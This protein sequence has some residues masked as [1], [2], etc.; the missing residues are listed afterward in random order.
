MIKAPGT[1]A[2]YSRFLFALFSA[3][4]ILAV[5]L[6]S[7]CGSNSDAVIVV[8]SEPIMYLYAEQ[9]NSQHQGANIEVHYNS[10]P[11]D[12]RNKRQVMPD[13]LIQPNPAGTYQMQWFQPLSV[14]LPQETYPQL[15][16]QYSEVSEKR[17]L[18][19]AF[20]LP[21]MVWHGDQPGAELP[22]TL[23]INQLA[24]MN[25]RKPGEGDLEYVQFLP[26][27]NPAFLHWHLRSRGIHLNFQEEGVPS[28]NKDELMRE[29]SMLQDW[30][31][32]QAGTAAQIERFQE[33]YLYAPYYALLR[34]ERVG[35]YAADLQEYASLPA[36][37]KE[38]LD[39]AWFGSEG[40]IPVLSVLYAAIPV[41]SRHK[42]EAQQFLQWLISP[43]TQKE[44][45]EYTLEQELPDFGFFG[46]L[47]A[48][49]TVNEE[50]I[51]R[52]FPQLQG[53]SPVSSR[54][55]FPPPMPYYWQELERDVIA[56]FLLD[57]ILED[58]PPQH[59]ELQQRINNWLA[60]QP[61]D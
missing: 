22:L 23:G 11:V 61:K 17:L 41:E 60:Q 38:D 1:I 6:L 57:S 50:E 10:N 34:Q 30:T 59:D 55:I 28:W 9:Y 12:Y 15:A 58:P 37:L 47:S 35:Y 21:I 51:P 39:F 40:H 5:L 24:E 48:N 14:R 45:M 53:K 42:K 27:W 19:L 25:T 44:L 3:C 26:I 32:E 20:S 56:P 31:Q 49:S 18:P 33:H 29:V 16:A 8:S 36:Q 4:G 52:L 13:I 2:S 46:R 43:E 54:L 7:S